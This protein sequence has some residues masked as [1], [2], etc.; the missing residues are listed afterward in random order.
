EGLLGADVVGF[1]RQAD[2][3]NFLRAC[4][5]AAGARTSGGVVRVSERQPGPGRADQGAAE[6][7]SGAPAAGRRV[8]V[9]PFPISI[10]TAG[11]GELARRADVR[12]RSVQI[13]AE[14]GNPQVVLLGV[15]RLDY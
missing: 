1:Q 5:R 3:T 10:D 7:G 9:G 13:R 14:L 12:A 11:F 15:D 6:T 8:R 2:V 4:R